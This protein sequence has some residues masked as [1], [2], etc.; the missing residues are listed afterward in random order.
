MEGGKRKE[1]QDVAEDGDQEEKSR[2]RRSRRELESGASEGQS[3][4][5]WRLGLPGVQ[6]RVGRIQR[7]GGVTPASYRAWQARPR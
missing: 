7:L 6:C 4:S 2:L 3:N 5:G 1:R